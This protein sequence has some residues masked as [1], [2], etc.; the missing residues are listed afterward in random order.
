MALTLFSPTPFSI[1]NG[2][3]FVFNFSKF[4]FAVIEYFTHTR[5]VQVYFFI[6]TTTTTAATINGQNEKESQSQLIFILLG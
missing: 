3:L 4:K 5:K 2:Q 1:F 6:Q